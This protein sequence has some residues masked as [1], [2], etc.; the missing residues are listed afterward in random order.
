M[1]RIVIATFGSFGDV[2]PYMAVALALKAR[3]HHPVIATSSIYREKMQAAG[4]D[5]HPVRPD[6]PPPE[7]SE[8]L[9][10]RVMNRHTGTFYVIRELVLPYVRE[11]YADL[12]AALDDASLLVSHP[13]TWAAPLI[14]EKRKLKWISSVLAP[15]SF[16]SSYDP[17]H[18]PTMQWL[19]RLYPLGP[20]VTGAIW[21][22]FKHL[23]R[24]MVKPVDDLRAE[25]GLARSQHPL[26]EGQHSPRLVLALFSSVLGQAQPDWP[27][28]TRITG[29]PFYDRLDK[30]GDASGMAQAL[31]DFLERGEPPIVFTLGSSAVWVAE[32]FYRHSLRAARLLRRRAVLLI[33]DERNLPHEEL[34]DDVL[35]VT[36]APYSEILP[37]AAAVV[38]Q[39]GVGTTAQALRAGRPALVV[40]YAHD[41]A[42]N[43]ARVT[44]MGVA[45]TLPR[46]RYTAA[47]A[48]AELKELLDNPAYRQKAEEVGGRVR[49]EDGASAAAAAIEEVLS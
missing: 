28:N 7:E 16:L 25:L 21:S 9:L 4:I 13:L 33:G 1:K 23:S 34:G 3:G 29:F 11:T 30:A 22:V 48:A 42:D 24:P 44:R 15:A 43:A 45:R 19:T 49:R 26:F 47:R 39:G 38:H 12:S 36:Y 17:P 14:A 31:T 40:P 32:D 35:A 20:G 18:P 41:Q 46:H 5:F 8:E 27:Q 37:R 2:H 10:R 6:L